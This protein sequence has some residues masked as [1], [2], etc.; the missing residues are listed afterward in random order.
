MSISL[1]VLDP[2]HDPEPAYWRHLQA[3]TARPASWSYELLRLASWNRRV[4]LLVSVLRDGDAL[5]GVVCAGLP[6]TA[7]RPGAFAPPHGRPA[8]SILDVFVPLTS[9]EPG[10]WLAAETGERRAELLAAY[11]TGMR[12][13]LGRHHRGVLWREVGDVDSGALPGRVRLAR[14]LNP[15]A[16]LVT[17]WDDRDGW[18]ASLGKSRTVDLRR[19]LRQ[20]EADPSVVSA[21]GP[22]RALVKGAE[23]ADLKRENELKYSGRLAPPPLPVSYLE[24]LIGLDE[25]VAITFRDT[26]GRLIAV[27]LILDHPAWPLFLMWGALPVGRGGRR[28]LYFV[29]MAEAV[30]WTIAR[31]GKGLVLGK[32]KAALKRDL[33]AD[34]VPCRAV[35][36]PC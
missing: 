11:A 5:C 33:G 17:P 9:A 7:W 1:E 29:A 6:G 30:G 20:I 21:M 35:A 22:A 2:R 10:W 23:I 34:F 27:S 15:V 13:E 31:R 32:G 28:H 24:A 14:P 25:A 26:A 12:A 3:R 4:P 16:R 36:V 19:Q 18:L 8:L